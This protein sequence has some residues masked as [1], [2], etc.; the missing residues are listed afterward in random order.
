MAQTLLVV[1]SILIRGSEIFN[2]FISFFLFV[3]L[4]ANLIYLIF[5]FLLLSST[6]EHAM[7]P[8]YGEKWGTECLNT[9]PPLPTL[10]HVRYIVKLKKNT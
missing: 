3:L 2:I 1:D 7:S 4:E 8:E 5:F 6:T 10:L 9:R